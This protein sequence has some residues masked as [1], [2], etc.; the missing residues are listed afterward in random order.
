MKN[1]IAGFGV[2]F[3]CLLAGCG[4]G[5]GGGGGGS[6]GNPA[7]QPV[8]VVSSPA[9]QVLPATF[10]FGKV[11]TGN[12]PVPLEVT[13][14]NTGAATLRVSSIGFTATSSPAFTLSPT[15]GTNPC[16]SGAPEIAAGSSCTFGV[17]FRP[18]GSGTFT[19]NIQIASNDGASPVFGVPITGTS[20]AVSA[21]TVRI[22]QVE[23]SP[24]CQ[25]NSATAYVSVMD[26]GGF[27]LTGLTTGNFTLTEGAIPSANLL[28]SATRVDAAYKPLA[29][30]AVVDN[31]ASISGQPV[32]F[33]DMKKGFEGLFTSLR[34]NDVGGLI[35]FGSVYEVTVAFPSPV[36]TSNPTNKA[37]LV[38]GLTVPWTK[39]ANTLLYDSVYKAID[40]AA[41]QTGYRRAVIVATDGVDEGE[42]AGVPL[43]TQT[44]SGVI[45]N[46]LSKGVPVFTI[47]IGGSVNVAVLQEMATQT[48]GMFFLANT[49]QNLATIYQQ[50]SSQLF[51]DQYVLTFNQLALGAGTVSPLQVGVVSPTGIV[52]SAASTITSC[53]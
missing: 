2:L 6:S 38:S 34:A 5:G 1:T 40:D 29:I 43:S 28:L 16:G 21:L 52:G 31:S 9:M 14:R 33:A 45:A 15:T 49:S 7:P 53:N 19:S 17:A 32:T 48:G 18:T 13:I 36:S 22:N 46:A 11:T 12:T 20:E 50:L 4:G 3:V 24:S 37:A 27:P 23:T 47:G 51:Q 10:D 42:S 41:L 39:D 26:Q 30:A 44:L 8:V 25:N 35:S